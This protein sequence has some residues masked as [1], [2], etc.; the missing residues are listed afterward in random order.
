MN[1]E[2]TI[3]E[4]VFIISSISPG[5]FNGVLTNSEVWCSVKEEHLT[6]LE[7]EDTD[8]ILTILFPFQFF[9]YGCVVQ[10]ELTFMIHEKILKQLNC[11]IIYRENLNFKVWCTE[12]WLLWKNLNFGETRRAMPKAI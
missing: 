11:M 10:I 9:F 1:E 2:G 4:I 7:S 8:L 6:L 3:D 5:M 12:R